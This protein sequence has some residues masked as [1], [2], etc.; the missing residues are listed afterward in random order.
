LFFKSFGVDADKW[1]KA[2]LDL[3]PGLPDLTPSRKLFSEKAPQT[4]IMK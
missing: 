2:V 4:S 1:E 3:T